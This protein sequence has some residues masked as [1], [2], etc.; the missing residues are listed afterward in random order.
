MPFTL[1]LAWL[2]QF[3][4]E[5]TTDGQ[6]QLLSGNDITVSMMN[7]TASFGYTKGSNYQAIE[8]PYDGQE[9]SMVIMMPQADRF[10]AFESSLTSQQ[11][12]E[13]IKGLQYQRVSLTMPKFKV[14]SQFGLKD[15][16]S[17]MGMP[18][19]FD[20][21][22]FS[23]MDGKKDLA[24]SDVVHKAYVSVDENGTEAAAATGVIMSLTAV[25]A[26]PIQVT[27]DHPFIFFIR[28]IQTGTVLFIGR[29]MNPGE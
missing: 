28:D 6:F 13:I 24:V 25:Q 9:L 11:V 16:L 2:S 4:P 21:A 8:L 18:A 26:E 14:E 10:Q 15:T 17:A 22:D 20:G 7:Q 27:I 23:G 1:T 19:A 3:K 12:S 29:V 5:A